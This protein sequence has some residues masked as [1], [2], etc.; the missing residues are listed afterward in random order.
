[1]DRKLIVLLTLV[2]TGCSLMKRSPRSEY[3]DDPYE[4]TIEQR[5][6]TER[7][8][9]YVRSADELGYEGIQKL[10]PNQDLRVKMRAKLRIMENRLI[11]TAEKKQYYS[12]K[13]YM[14][15][16]YQRIQFLALPPSQ[17]QAFLENQGILKKDY[18]SEWNEAIEKNDV[19][20]YMSREAVLESWGQ[21][22][23]RQVAGNPVYGNEKWVYEDF[24]SDET[25]FLKKE[26]VL[27][28]E[29]GILTSW[30]TQ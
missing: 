22:Q 30:E 6:R 14:K 13:A 11:T 16:D 18:R 5:P 19:V 17:R 15:N 27:F 26:K 21:P 29:N 24:G 3:Y 12:N 7:D 2:C 1:M 8:L 4:H 10:S 20:P 23:K 28:F 25:G 9:A